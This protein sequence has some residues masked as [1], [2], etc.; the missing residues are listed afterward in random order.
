[1][2][3]DSKRFGRNFED[4]N[5]PNERPADYSKDSQFNRAA[6]V[7]REFDFY[8]KINKVKGLDNVLAH[9][10]KAREVRGHK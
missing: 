7:G 8:A 2:P 1:M 10:D 9:G 6:A 4:N 5:K 3:N